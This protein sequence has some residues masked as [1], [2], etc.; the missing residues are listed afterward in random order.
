MAEEVGAR[1]V[2]SWVAGWIGIDRDGEVCSIA[3][4]FHGG[5]NGVEARNHR[6]EEGAK[7][8]WIEFTREKGDEIVGARFSK[9]F[10]QFARSSDE[11]CFFEKKVVERLIFSDTCCR[12]VGKLF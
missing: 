3:N 4:L 11:I 10:T 5:G 6:S 12:V 9:P 8:F 7:L 1:P 2:G